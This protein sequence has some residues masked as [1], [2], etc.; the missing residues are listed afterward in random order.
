MS[1]LYE[2][3]PTNTDAYHPLNIEHI[4]QPVNIKR[5]ILLQSRNGYKDVPQRTYTTNCNQQTIDRVVDIMHPDGRNLKHVTE[6]EVATHVPSI[7]TLS[8]VPNK[9]TKI[10]NGWGIERLQFLLEVDSNMGN[11]I[12]TSYIQGYSDYNDVSYSNHID[13]RI[14]YYINS[15]TTVSKIPDPTTGTYITRPYMSFNVIRDELGKE[16]INF[17]NNMTH[18]VLVRPSDL[19]KNMYFTNDYGNGEVK[20]INTTDLVTPTQ[21]H[22]SRKSNANPVK[23]FTNIVNGYI[24]GKDTAEISNNVADILRS[25]A[26]CTAD[27]IYTNLAFVRSLT[28]LN[29]DLTPTSFTIM[30]LEMLDP[31]IAH[32]TNYITRDNYINLGQFNTMLDTN[33]TADAFQ[34]T[35][36]NTKAQHLASVI[37][38]IMIETF[39]T[40]LTISITNIMGEPIIT[41]LLFNTFIDGI[42]TTA[43][44]NRLIHK[45]QLE[46]VP[47]ITDFGASSVEILFTSNIMGDTTISLNINNSGNLIYRFPTFCD[48]LYT[49]V[50]SNRD[51]STLIQ[52]DLTQI[53]DATYAAGVPNFESIII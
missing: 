28:N 32:K 21:A 6:A 20:P 40:D 25:A 31:S 15:I 8:S 44:I 30:D 53:V 34:P 7:V 12:F 42:D 49:P 35:V 14:R 5:F 18:D 19:Y 4:V 41:P 3:T 47:Y 10:H 26:S 39:I 50:I 48:S 22:V 37:P 23:Y 46:V 11:N 52:N 29:G 38:S 9:I 27:G 43:Y 2:I 17:D 16:V 24:S 36:L 51:R 1:T 33:D 45:L 13:P